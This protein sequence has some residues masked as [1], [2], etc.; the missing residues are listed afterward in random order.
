M[1]FTIFK[2]LGAGVILGSL[3]FFA[4]PLLLIVLLLKFIFTPF[5]MNRWRFAGPSPLQMWQ[6]EKVRSMSAEE[7]DAF[8]DNIR[9]PFYCKEK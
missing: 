9:R 2:A 5:G 3:V 6:L 7:F 8:K 4:G 1:N